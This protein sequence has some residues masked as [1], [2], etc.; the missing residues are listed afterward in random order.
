MTR[1][2]AQKIVN[3]Y[4]L[5]AHRL[6]SGVWVTN[7]MGKNVVETVD[8]QR[9]EPVKNAHGLGSTEPAEYATPQGCGTKL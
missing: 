3:I 7:P 8:A 2:E 9:T 5:S 1:E 4:G 6:E